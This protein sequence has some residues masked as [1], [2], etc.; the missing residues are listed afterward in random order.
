[1]SKKACFFIEA[2]AKAHA[3]CLA[4]EAAAANKQEKVDQNFN[5]S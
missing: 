1:M 5:F 3:A 2:A 4:Q